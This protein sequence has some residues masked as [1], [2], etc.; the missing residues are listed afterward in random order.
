MDVLSCKIEN[1]KDE[2]FDTN[3]NTKISEKHKYNT[4]TGPKFMD[5]LLDK[6]FIKDLHVCKVKNTMQRYN[7]YFVSNT[8][9]IDFFTACKNAPQ[10]TNHMCMFTKKDINIFV[11]LYLQMYGMNFQIDPEI[12]DFIESK[13]HE[14]IIEK[15]DKKQK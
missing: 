7:Q 11:G 1:C 8:E 15:Y 9:R 14:Y 2:H 5:S 3:I 10:H 6:E 13:L 4:Q 12:I